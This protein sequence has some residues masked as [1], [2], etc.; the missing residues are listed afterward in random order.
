MQRGDESAREADVVG[1][2][3]GVQRT[4]PGGRRCHL[5]RALLQ[6]FLAHAA[7]EPAESQR[8]TTDRGSGSSLVTYLNT[9]V[10][11]CL[12]NG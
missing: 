10:I 11:C 9:P 6:W 4:R 5:A 7:I 1:G 2:G 8:Q 12:R 3:C